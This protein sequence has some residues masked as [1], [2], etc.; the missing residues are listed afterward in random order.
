MVFSSLA[1]AARRH[2]R[3]VFPPLAVAVLIDSNPAQCPLL[4][5]HQRTVF[6]VNTSETVFPPLAVAV[7]IDSN[8]AECPPLSPHQRKVFC[9]NT[10]ETNYIHCVDICSWGVSLHW[11]PDLVDCFYKE[12][13]R[14]NVMGTIFF[15][16]IPEL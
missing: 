14:R 1:S 16:S 13:Q 11:F 9:V 7:L 12:K 15:S 2:T 6:C 3:S 5:P 8:P 4:S 10:S